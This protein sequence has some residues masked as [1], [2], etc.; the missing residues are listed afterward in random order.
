[1]GIIINP[2]EPWVGRACAPKVKERSACVNRRDDRSMLRDPSGQLSL[3]ATQVADLLAPN[4]SQ[5][6]QNEAIG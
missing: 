1:L 2:G 5:L 4:V 3:T 6:L